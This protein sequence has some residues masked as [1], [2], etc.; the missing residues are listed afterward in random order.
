MLKKSN[1]ELSHTCMY[2]I[3]DHINIHLKKLC[4]KHFSILQA[5]FSMDSQ[6]PC[7][8]AALSSEFCGQRLEP[9]ETIPRAYLSDPSCGQTRLPAIYLGPD[10][11]LFPRNRPSGTPVGFISLNCMVWPHVMSFLYTGLPCFGDLPGW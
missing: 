6:T 5:V 4:V 8:N 1:R 10:F 11:V 9:W 2:V 7:D 3:N